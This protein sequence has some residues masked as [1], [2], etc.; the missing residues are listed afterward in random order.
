MGGMVDKYM[1]LGREQIKATI[2]KE[3]L[4]ASDVLHNVFRIVSGE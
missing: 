3:N 2:S 4:G 1:R